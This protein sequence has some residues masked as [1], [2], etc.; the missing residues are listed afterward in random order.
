MLMIAIVAGSLIY[1][2]IKFNSRR[3]RIN[4]DRVENALSKRDTEKRR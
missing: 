1:G 3:S 4:Y 2:L